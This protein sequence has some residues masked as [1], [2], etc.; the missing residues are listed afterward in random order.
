MYSS[1]LMIL[2]RKTA[3]HS[4]HMVYSAVYL[5]YSIRVQVLHLLTHS[6][7]DVF[8]KSQL[9]THC[10]WCIAPCIQCIVY[11]YRRC[12]CIHIPYMISLA[13][14]RCTLIAHCVY[15]RLHSIWCILQAY[16]RCICIR[17]AYIIFLANVSQIPIVHGVQCRVFSVWYTCVGVAYTYTLHVLCLSQTSAKYSL[18]MLC[19]AI[20]LVY[21]IL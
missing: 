2:S 6:I 12:I 7:Y 13:K 16:K 18:H 15:C 10:T 1:K 21:S 9:Y 14:V 3:K 5:V 19:S 8:C 17:I 20:Y 11:V 4:W